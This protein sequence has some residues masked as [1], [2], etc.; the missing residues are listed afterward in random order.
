MC[1]CVC[2]FSQ[3]QPGCND[4][5]DCSFLRSRPGNR[6][7]ECHPALSLIVY[8]DHEIKMNESQIKQANIKLKAKA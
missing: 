3:D 4:I 5:L 8:A 7:K 6:M 2:V 1:V